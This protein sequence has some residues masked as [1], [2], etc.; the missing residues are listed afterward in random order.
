[1][2][3]YVPPVLQWFQDKDT[4]MFCDFLRRW[5]TLKAAQRARRTTLETFCRD[6]HGPSADVI[7][8][9]LR[10]IKTATPLTTDEGVIAPNTLLVQPLPNSASPCRPSQPSPPPSR[11]GPSPIPT[12]PSSKPSQALGLSA[13]PAS[14]SPVATNT[15]A[16]PLPPNCK[17]MRAL[18]QSPH[19]AARRPGCTGAS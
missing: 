2:N 18:P 12:S 13:L 3:N 8:Q 7:A 6:H 10:A 17:N 5:P 1:L 16:M 9:R 4:P 14:S 15:R 19:A 11:S